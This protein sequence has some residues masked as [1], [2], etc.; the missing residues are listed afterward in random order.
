MQLVAL[1]ETFDRDDVG[2][3]ERDGERRAG[4]DR[5]AIDMDDAGAALAGVAADMGA[6]EA[7]VLAQI[8][9]EQRTRLDVSADLLPVHR[10]GHGGHE[11]SSN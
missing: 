6:G 5:L 10:H 8:L 7:Q 11:H 4:L 3:L 9:D 1:G 2:A